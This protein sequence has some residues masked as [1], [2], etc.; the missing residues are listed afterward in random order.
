MKIMEGTEEKNKSVFLMIFPRA[1]D[2]MKK[3]ESQVMVIGEKV[4]EILYLMDLSL[5]LL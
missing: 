5:T 4:M 2:I 3:M 1:R